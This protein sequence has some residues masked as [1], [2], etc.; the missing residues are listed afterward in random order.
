M[1]PAG[2][3]PCRPGW[4]W[5]PCWRRWCPWP[6]S[7]DRLGP[8]RHARAR[9]GKYDRRRHRNEAIIAISGVALLRIRVGS[10]RACRLST[11]CFVALEQ[12]SLARAHR[13]NFENLVDFLPIAAVA[14]AWNGFIGARE[15]ASADQNQRNCRDGNGFGRCEPHSQNS[16]RFVIPRIHWN[17]NRTV[18][19]LAPHASSAKDHFPRSA[20][21][22][23]RAAQADKIR[24]HA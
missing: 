5:P 10:G 15:T 3:T 17:P 18:L 9:S 22:F 21:R 23:A 16:P 7:I 6:S 13:G 11:G 24:P 4:R 19:R 1:N 12:V 8:R 14:T 20:K 2:T